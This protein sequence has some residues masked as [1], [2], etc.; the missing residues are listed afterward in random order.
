MS[1]ALAFS[2]TRRQRRSAAM[3]P[4]FGSL[5]R[6]VPAPPAPAR[7]RSRS[8]NAP[9]GAAMGSALAMRAPASGATPRPLQRAPT[10]VPCVCSLRRVPVPMGP[11]RTRRFKPAARKGARAV[12]VRTTHVRGGCAT[13]LPPMPAPIVR[14]GAS[15]TATARAALVPAV[16]PVTTSRAPA[17]RSAAPVHA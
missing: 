13:N 2:A 6:A 4:T 7:T 8:S 17:A 9:A 10:R 5:T 12:L 3:P 16:T 14:L 15:P 11:V 1:R